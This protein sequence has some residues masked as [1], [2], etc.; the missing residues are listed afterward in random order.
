MRCSVTVPMAFC[1]GTLFAM[2]CATGRSS[3]SALR[4]VVTAAEPP[5]V[6]AA[7]AAVASAPSCCDVEAK[8]AVLRE[9]LKDEERWFTF[10]HYQIPYVPF[11]KMSWNRVYPEQATDLQIDI[12]W[13]QSV[14]LKALDTFSGTES[15][16]RKLIDEIEA[17]FEKTRELRRA[18][19]RDVYLKVYNIPAED[20]A[21]DVL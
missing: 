9:R 1:A 18:F 5:V 3:D 13:L 11:R 19:I 17:K 15:E 4:P 10:I 14:D 8:I 2:A 21:Y 7:P 16:R 20:P 6:D 12:E